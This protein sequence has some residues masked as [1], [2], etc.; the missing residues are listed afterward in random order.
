MNAK[1]SYWF[2]FYSGKK[3]DDVIKLEY[4]SKGGNLDFCDIPLRAI[5]RIQKEY[6]SREFVKRTN[7]KDSLY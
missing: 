6:L 1:L 5:E 3:K 2:K 4:I 7:K